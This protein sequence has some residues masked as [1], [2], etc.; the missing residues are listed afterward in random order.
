M[1]SRRRR[2]EQLQSRWASGE[3]LSADEERER[4]DYAALDPAAQRELELFAELRNRAAREGDTVS[5]ALTDSV[6]DAVQER[7]RLRLV[8]STQQGADRSYD[9]LRPVWRTRA[10]V[11]AA[12][13]LVTAA[14]G[15]TLM[16]LPSAAP[17]RVAA[18]SS[19]QPPPLGLAAHAVLV[20]AAGDVLVGGRPA[21]VGQDP[22]REGQRVTTRNGRACLTIDSDVDV[23]LADD[24]SVQLQWLAAQS[25]RLQ[26]ESG[27]V[28]A[29]LAR[30]APGST[31]S[32]IMDELSATAR[33][34]TFAARREK[35]QREV[36][37]LDGVVDVVHGGERRE[38]VDAHSRVLVHSAVGPF[39][40]MPVDSS[41]EA[42]LLTLRSSHTLWTGGDLGVL[43]VFAA[44][45]AALRASIDDQALLPLPLRMFVRVGK[46][47]LTW[48][49]AA[50]AETSSWVDVTSGETN[51]VE[52]PLPGTVAA[53]HGQPTEKRSPTALLEAARRE[54]ARARPREA[55][56]LY[57]K[58]RAEYPDSPE[59]RTVLVTMGKL[60]LNLGRQERALRRFDAYV[61]YG[62]ALAQEA[63]AGKIRALRALRRG[64]EERAA[65]R[66]YLARH[67]RGLEAPLFE[68]RLQELGTQ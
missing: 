25:I 23:C 45:S 61:E 64:E 1:S 54:V 5:L 39:E 59:A 56:A 19:T 67:P 37:V 55:L 30:R 63:L 36:I 66:Q 13:L 57:E 47:R 52:P 2:W 42:R 33:G 31:F 51:H 43:R 9:E 32:L 29:S 48:R 38:R 24:S 41:E 14:F 26:V 65:I 20:L 27:T 34:T 16:M 44:S 53:P 10:L 68:K 4:L 7:P 8:S 40:R 50:G 18:A 22:I 46:H 3:R 11:M 15:G 28:L 60:E 49:D 12:A 17:R 35:G 21:G 62:G 6:L 58:L